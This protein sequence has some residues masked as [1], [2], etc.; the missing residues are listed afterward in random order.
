MIR[1]RSDIMVGLRFLEVTALVAGYLE[2]G[3]MER[4]ERTG[5][6]TLNGVRM[7]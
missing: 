4:K 7:G 3:L 5:G 6:R 1:E 2:W